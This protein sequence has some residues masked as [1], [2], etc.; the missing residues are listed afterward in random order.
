VTGRGL[1]G[2][3]RARERPAGRARS[4]TVS[5]QLTPGAWP[6]ALAYGDLS[7]HGNRTRPERA[8]PGERVPLHIFEPRYREL[9]GEC[10]ESGGAFGLLFADEDGIREV[11]TRASV[12]EVLERFPDERL[13]VVVEGGER[14]RVTELTRGRSFRTA[15][16]EPLEDEAAAARPADRALA[17]GAFRALAQLAGEDPP[18]PDPDEL[19][20]NEAEREG[21]PLS[22]ALAA[23]VQLPPEPKQRLLESRSESERLRLVAALFEQA[24]RELVAARE[25]RE[26]AG[27]NGSR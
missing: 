23:R 7:G 24:G 19:A 2:R 18:E 3:L 10:L 1:R 12:V 4:A 26:R 8:R 5:P 14:F 9:I 16:V 15:L 17:L 27:R 11:G 6:R 25:L 21:P 22:F 13:N 20:P